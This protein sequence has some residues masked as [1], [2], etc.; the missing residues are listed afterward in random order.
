MTRFSRL[1]LL[2]LLALATTLAGCA[3]NEDRWDEIAASGVLRIGIDP[4]YPPFAA[5]EGNNVVGLDIDLAQALA[6]ELGLEPKF[7]YFGYDGLYDAL[8]TGQVDMLI[9]ALVVAPER[10]KDVAFTPGYFDAGQ[11]LIVPAN[12]NNTQGMADLAGRRLA[13]EQG[14]L[15]HVTALEWQRRLPDM[16]VLPFTSVDEAMDALTAGAADAA[17]VDHVGAR[18]H[19]AN[20]PA[21]QSASFQLLPEPV[22]PEPYVIA[23]R[24]D[25]QMLLRELT[26]G[27]QKLKDNGEL[28]L[29]IKRW[30]AP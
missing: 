28:D 15:G 6:R 8:T 30:L 11:F 14:A 19:A 9:S 25:D 13:V 7:V 10:T 17:L 5:A 22:V 20:L 18:L 12:N 23:L 2:T 3:V 16:T 21:G 26:A 27:I 4:T 24:I 1:S 29:I